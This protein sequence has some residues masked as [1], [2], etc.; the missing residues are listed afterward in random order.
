MVACS[1]FSLRLSVGRPPFDT[2]LL[3]FAGL[4]A[5]ASYGGPGAAP[6]AL[7]NAPAR[8]TGL[9]QH[10]NVENCL[11]SYAYSAA[12]GCI[13]DEERAAKLVEF[14]TISNLKWSEL[15]ASGDPE[16]GSNRL[17]AVP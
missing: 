5:R 2:E 15:G 17:N 9:Q 8:S 3:P 10:S 6:P 1:R 11:I 12:A 7:H 16:G 4:Q 13:H 14:Q